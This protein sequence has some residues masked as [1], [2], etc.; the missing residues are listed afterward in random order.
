MKKEKQ[1]NKLGFKPYFGTT[2][3]SATQSL[4][5]C[6]MTSYFMLYLT[7]YSGL[8]A[9]GAT[10]GSILL[11]GARIFDA[12]NDPLEGWI[13]D[14]AKPGKNGKYRP[15]LILSIILMTVGVAA[16][17]F[18]P[19][20]ITSTPILV[21]AY[22]IIAYLLYDIGFSFFTPELVYRTMTLDTGERG[23]LLIGPRMMTMVMG[24]FV[25]ALVS[26]VTVVNMKINDL[27]TS[28]GIVVL[29]FCLVS[30]V[31]SLIGV[32]MVKE[33]YMPESQE[34]DPVKLTDILLLFKDNDAFRVRVAA[35]LFG[36]FIYTLMYAAC[37]YY[38]KWAYC[39][40]LTTGAVDTGKYGLFVLGT[41]MI[42]FSPLILGTLLATPIMKK[43]GS[44]DKMVRI[45]YLFQAIPLG[46]LFVAQ[47]IGILQKS[48]V[49]FF[50]CMTITSFAMGT[51][52][53]PTGVLNMESMDYDV[54]KNGRERSA[55]NMAAAKLL[56]KG[57]SALA[58]A[59]VGV[60]L[61][62]I[63][64]VVDSQTDTFLGD[65]SAIPSM[66]NWF[67]VIM[68]LVPCIFGIIA[69]LIYRKY[70]ITNEIREKMRAE[71]NK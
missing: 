5:S 70:P 43:I 8:G 30:A 36:G 62:S 46:I 55:L 28:F 2:I 1:S 58:T 52:F 39:A 56:E 22:V 42:S 57:Q 64:Y 45:M 47:M 20:A 17:F 29:I 66:L 26:I 12:V 16:L 13:I 38:A 63:G 18:I 68:G 37:N 7:D 19:Q 9:L 31:I 15:F 69:V 27:H 41:S 59:A 14:R 65:L 53:V 35:A 71:I 48:P 67:T 25:S 54:Y 61:T 34:E 4:V 33:K 50:A 51:S 44:P 3:M 40:D 10:L 24:I 6:L 60:V 49:I 11:V 32:F 23:K 21:G